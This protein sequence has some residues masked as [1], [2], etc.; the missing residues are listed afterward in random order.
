M[1]RREEE[2]EKRLSKISPLV[3]NYRECIY[4]TFLLGLRYFTLNIFKIKVLIFSPK[5]AVPAFSS[6]QLVSIASFNYSKQNRGS[7]YFSI[8]FSHFTF[9][10]SGNSVGST[11]IKICPESKCL[12]I[13]LF[14]TPETKKKKCLESD[15]SSPSAWLSLWSKLPSLLTCITNIF[16]TGVSVSTFASYLQD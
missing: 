7:Y 1:E 9:N 4:S 13:I 2:K 11:V 10:S 5:P 12:V 16:L 14:C 8:L 6:S 3:S 15:R